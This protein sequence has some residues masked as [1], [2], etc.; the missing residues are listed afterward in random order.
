M[1][2]VGFTEMLLLAVIALI[3]VGPHRLPK[4]ARTAGQLTR[5][6]RNAW[7]NLQTELQAE[8]DAEHNRKIMQDTPA[9]S[10]NSPPAEKPAAASDEPRQSD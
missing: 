1:S 4:I 6:A 9:D 2:G 5:Q 7:Q 8:L 10:S 3:V